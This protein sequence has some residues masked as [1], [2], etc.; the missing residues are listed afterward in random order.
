MQWFMTQVIL[1]TH[2]FFSND[3]PEI[4][5]IT[6]GLWSVYYTAYGWCAMSN[7]FLMCH[8]FF[9]LIFENKIYSLEFD[10]NSKLMV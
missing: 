3:M 7:S 8:I 4:T 1:K 10:K 6:I 2:E 9:W 5:A